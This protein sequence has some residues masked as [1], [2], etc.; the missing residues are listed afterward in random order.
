GRSLHLP[1]HSRSP[2]YGAAVA[3]CR[4][5]SEADEHVVVSFRYASRFCAT[6]PR[7]GLRVRFAGGWSSIALLPLLRFAGIVGLGQTLANDLMCLPGRKL[8]NLVI[9]EPTLMQLLADAAGDHER[10]RSDRRRVGFFPFLRWWAGR[11]AHQTGT[12]L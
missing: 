10:Y 9:G 1:T 6:T 11:G 5:L 3:F 4:D 7:L 2:P 8:G 12:H